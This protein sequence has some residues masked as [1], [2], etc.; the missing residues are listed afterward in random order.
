MNIAIANLFNLCAL[1]Y[2]CKNLLQYK[3]KRKYLHYFIFCITF[4]LLC[5]INITGA[6][7]KKSLIIFIIYLLYV[8]LQFKDRIFNIFWAT[9]PFYTF[10]LLSELIIGV[11]LN[12]FLDFHKSTQMNS[13]LFNIGLFCSVSLLLFFSYIF[14]KFIHYLQLY[15]FPAYCEI[16]FV[17]PLA[18]VLLLSSLN[19]YYEI[20]NNT[21][22]ILLIFLC[23]LISNFS[24]LII[25]FL[26][27]Q[28][29]KISSDLKSSQYEK[30]IIDTKYN[31]LKNHYN[32]NFHFLHD[33]LHKCHQMN[34]FIENN[35]IYN[36]KKELNSLS[37]ITF[38]K[39]N[40]IY[41]NSLALNYVTNNYINQLQEN[42]I[43]FTS[44]I[45]Y[46]DFSFLDLNTQIDIFSKFLDY[47]I[48]LNKSISENYRNIIIK[49]NKFGEQ[50]IISAI[51][52]CENIDYYTKEKMEKD[53]LAILKNINNCNISIKSNSNTS[54]SIVLYFININPLSKL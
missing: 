48:L 44:T 53:F 14:V 16:I 22:I 17:F 2:I 52:K 41:S 46:N 33:L 45:K 47:G 8:F 10:S 40:S 34:T 35:D 12:Y 11:I 4:F 19:N 32:N 37:D 6:S 43:K 23:I 13:I 25:F 49:S 54:I 39:F 20:I 26:F 30:N 21:A 18:T 51:I 29:N 42:K 50:V 28:S 27:M 7:H 3:T 9:I 24:I 36:L 1:H 5:F 38:N 15:S 31:L